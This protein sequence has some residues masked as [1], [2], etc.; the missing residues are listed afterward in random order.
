MIGLVP[1]HLNETVVEDHLG[2]VV[3]GARGVVAVELEDGQAL[4][5]VHGDVLDGA[6]DGEEV[7]DLRLL[8][9]LL[10]NLFDDDCCDGTVVVR[11]GMGEVCAV[12]ATAS[13][14]HAASIA[15][16]P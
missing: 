13:R 12:P 2:A 16:A 4:V 15:A 1:V 6:E 3:G 14:P 10:G 7:A 9:V 8:E 11:T 5:G